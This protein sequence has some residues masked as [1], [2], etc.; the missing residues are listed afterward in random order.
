MIPDDQYINILKETYFKVLSLN[1][2]EE[3]KFDGENSQLGGR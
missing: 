3:T 1:S 2:P